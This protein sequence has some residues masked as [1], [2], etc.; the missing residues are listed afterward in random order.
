M[1]HSHKRPFAIR[2][3]EAL[4]P[5]I[6]NASILFRG[7]FHFAPVFELRVEQD[8]DRSNDDKGQSN[9]GD[10]RRGQ[11]NIAVNREKIESGHPGED[12]ERSP[13]K[14]EKSQM[15][16]L[17]REIAIGEQILKEPEDKSEN[18]DEP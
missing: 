1:R 17:V 7:L 15:I 8:D 12:D 2:K 11:I 5:R 10:K 18:A 14:E 16:P 9:D 13:A 3:D 6:G 4:R